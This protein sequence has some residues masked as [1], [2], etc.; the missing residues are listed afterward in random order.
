MARGHS[1]LI[2]NKKRYIVDNI[3]TQALTPATGFCSTATDLCKFFSAHYFG[4][5]FLISDTSKREMHHGNWGTDTQQ[6]RY[7]LG[8]T[9][10]IDGQNKMWGHGGGF[11]GYMTDTRFEPEQKLVISVLTNATDGPAAMISDR[12]AN[13]IDY[14]LENSGDIKDASKYEG[15]FFSQWGPQS[16]V[17]VNGKL[18]A[19][20][21]AF[22]SNFR[23]GNL[24]PLKKINNNTFQIEKASGYGSA[25]EEVRFNFGPNGKIKSVSFAGMDLIPEKDYL[26]K[27]NKLSR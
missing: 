16:I 2:F 13:I 3:S 18:I 15:T 7:G 11:P 22:W 19:T 17:N 1:N 6:E 10:Y 23:G 27:L 12:I 4:N 9:T 25:G 26:S 8:I 21:P 24:V 5:E 14:F 20:G